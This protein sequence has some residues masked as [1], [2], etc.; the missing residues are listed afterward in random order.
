MYDKDT[1]TNTTP[2]QAFFQLVSS[3]WSIK[4]SGTDN[5]ASETVKSISGK[6]KAGT[7][8][9]AQFAVQQTSGSWSAITGPFIYISKVKIVTPFD[10]RTFEGDVPEGTSIVNINGKKYLQVILNGWNSTFNILP[11]DIKKGYKASVEFKY[12][13]DTANSIEMSK[14]NAVVQLMDTV[15]KVT[16]PWGPGLVPSSVALSQNPASS[17]FATVTGSFS[18]EM[19]LVNQIQFFGQETVSWGPTTGDTIW[20]SPVSVS[21]SYNM[22]NLVVLDPAEV[23]PSTLPSWIKIV[24]INNNKYFQVVLD[25]WNSTINIMPYQLIPGLT[26]SCEYKYSRC[27]ATADSLQLSQINAMVQLMD[28]VNK[29]TNPWGPGMVPSS[30]GLLTS[31]PAT[32]TKVTKAMDSHMQLI[33]QVQFFGQETVTWGPTIGDTIWV[34]KITLADLTKPAAPTNLVAEV[35]DKKVKLTWTAATDND[36]IAGYIISVNDQVIDTITKTTFTTEDLNDGTY[37]FGVVAFDPSD[38][39]S[40]DVKSN[41]VVIS[42]SVKELASYGVNCFPNPVIDIL[43][44]QS[45]KNINSVTIYSITGQVQ[46][47][48]SINAN[49]ASIDLTNLNSGVYFVKIATE[50]G[51]KV[52]RI[53]KK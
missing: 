45:N 10:I 2:V 17:T 20:V 51:M 40:T 49:N 15:D 52:V 24:T 22:E 11:F 3:D 48:V 16:N 19:K 28:T 12:S 44:I 38:N 43:N 6:L 8:T 23:D 35:Q 50:D 47:I 41:A 33:N 26:A 39:V 36:K 25:G 34:G 18:K 53:I 13:C 21:A 5:P 37:V 32:F 27:A 14:I 4:A 29:V 30:T 31:A 9:I 46:R 7:F 1:S 42:T